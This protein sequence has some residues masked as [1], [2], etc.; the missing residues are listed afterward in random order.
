MHK[1]NETAGAARQ[2]GLGQAMVEVGLAVALPQFSDRYLDAQE[3]AKA[4][5][6]GS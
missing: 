5:K 2:V 1:H 6:L 4:L 3:R